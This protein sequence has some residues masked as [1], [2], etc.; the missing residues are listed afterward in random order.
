VLGRGP[1]NVV[2]ALDLLKGA[3]A[4]GWPGLSITTTTMAG[5][6]TRLQLAFGFETSPALAMGIAGLVGTILGHSFS[7]FT[8]FRGGKSVATGAGGFAVLFPV[9]MLIAL[10]VWLTTLGLSRY[11]SLASMVG[12]V[13]LP[14][15]AVLLHEPPA[16]IIA[17]IIITLFVILRH[18][19][20]IARLIAG[21]ESKVGGKPAAP[22]PSASSKP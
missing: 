10:V 15:A 14:I 18:R 21:T 22:T 4:S 5:T 6:G 16:L 7:C 13:S 3:L 19:A 1:G 8:G 12:A 11:V 2:L 20:N 17:S 9:G